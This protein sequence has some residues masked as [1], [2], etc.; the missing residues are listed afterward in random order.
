[1][2]AEYRDESE[3]NSEKSTLRYFSG[4]RN[5]HNPEKDHSL[6]NVHPETKMDTSRF[7]I[8]K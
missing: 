7:P 1:M 5:G 4:H 3:K 8:W 2:C 6:F